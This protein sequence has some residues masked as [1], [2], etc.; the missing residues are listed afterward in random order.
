MFNKLKNKFLQIDFGL[1]MIIICIS[2]I[3][4]NQLLSLSTSLMNKPST[5]MFNIGVFS[6]LILVIIQIVFLILGVISVRNY[7]NK[8][9]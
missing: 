4:S 2:I 5:L 3:I 8:T 9:K 7:I 6:T 1:Q